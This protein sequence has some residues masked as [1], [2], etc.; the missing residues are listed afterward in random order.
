MRRFLVPVLAVFLVV[1]CAVLPD[2]RSRLA[3]LEKA[4]EKTVTT[5]TQLRRDGVIVRGSST[6]AAID[7]GVTGLAG[8]LEVARAAVLQDA[9]SNAATTALSALAAALGQLEEQLRKAKS[10]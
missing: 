10:S 7:K 2:N 6:E 4:V 3:V 1:G 8:A 9:N 5:A